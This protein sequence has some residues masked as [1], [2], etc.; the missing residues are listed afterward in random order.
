MKFRSPRS[1][2]LSL[3]VTVLALF[4]CASPRPAHS[5]ALRAQAGAYEL[6]VLVDGVASR[7]FLHAGE[8]HVLGDQGSRYILRVHNR[9]GRRIEAVV[10]VD[11]LDVIDGKPADFANK[12][13]YLVSAY[14]YVDIEGWRL[15]EREAAA[16]RFA[17][18][19]ESY[20]A[21]TGKARNVGVI[22][23]AVFPER[24]VRPAPPVYVPEPRYHG[25][26]HERRSAPADDFSSAESY[27][28]AAPQKGR[29]ERESPAPAAATSAPSRGRASAEAKAEAPASSGAARSRA[30]SRGGL[31][32]EFGEAVS[33]EIRQ[34]AFV[35]AHSSRPSV[36][37]GARYND[38]S[39]LYA[40][41][42]DVDGYDDPSDLALRQS[43]RPFPVS[44]RGYAR[45]P[46]DWRND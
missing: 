32:T 30:P 25:G 28:S 44:Q 7:T 9:S 8:T 27:G 6:E 15:S 18:I 24:I 4:S 21:K 22:G 34:V 40:L 37:L 41:G 14:G 1:L 45:P 12:R 29:M 43:A 13:G 46:A 38:R 17:P 11:G 16:F 23:V 20:A 39:G 35:R 3:L 2:T 19:G 31:G 33:S 36:L 10:S 5:Q 42:I 26:S